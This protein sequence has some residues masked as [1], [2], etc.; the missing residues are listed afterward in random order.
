MFDHEGACGINCGFCA[1]DVFDIEFGDGD[2]LTGA[3]G[4][5]WDEGVP[6][7]AA[8]D[9]Y[10]GAFAGAVE[11]A[12]GVEKAGEKE[13]GKERDHAGAADSFGF[14]VADCE[15]RWDTSGGGNLDFF[16]C[17]DGGSHA[18]FDAAAFEGGTGG[19]GAGHHEFAVADDE[20]AIGADIDEEAQ[21]VGLV[22]EVGAKQAGGDVSAYITAYAGGE[23]DP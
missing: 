20:F 22:G 10:R 21:A 5:C 11:L 8:V 2:I 15:A 19:A 9:G 4:G 18:V 6:G 16:D 12:G 14:D 23:I 1:D 13:I 7:D 3:A 17:A